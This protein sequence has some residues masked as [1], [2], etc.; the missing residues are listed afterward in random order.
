MWKNSGQDVFRKGLGKAFSSMLLVVCL[1]A[2]TMPV[3]ADD[4]AYKTTTVEK[5]SIVVEAQ[6]QAAYEYTKA[7]PVVFEA[8]CGS[9]TFVQYTV[10]PNDF[11]SK[12]DVIAIISTG[13]DEIVLEETKLRLKRAEESRDITY[14]DMQE[15]YDA[16][17]KAVKDSSGTQK[18]IAEL[19]LE[20]LT[21]EQERSKRSIEEGIAAIQ[22]QMEAYEQVVGVTQIL[23]PA[24]GMVT[25]LTCWPNSTIWDGTQV[26]VIRSVAEAMFSV[27]DMGGVLR[28][29]MQ[30][31]LLD[32]IGNQ[33]VGR[34]VSSSPKYLSSSF[35]GEKA[36]VRPDF[37]DAWAFNVVYQNV[38]IDNVL[39][40]SSVAVKNDKDG[41]Y[42]VELKDGKLSKRYFTV[43]KIVNDLCY[44]I[45]GLTEGMTVI[46]N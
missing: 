33:Y 44:A 38:Q 12:G 3:S 31:T 20:K 36:Y 13:V 1:F 17:V 25:G 23:S 8:G 16:A 42:V 40:I 28:Y 2:E 22:E 6:M 30:V 15:Q 14:R 32:G 43:G 18:Q 7:V 39:I 35:N 4:S 10:N 41:T 45:D 19:R 21:M 34:V 9:T 5:G 29:G 11:V 26:A 27:K 46:V 24:G 37:Q